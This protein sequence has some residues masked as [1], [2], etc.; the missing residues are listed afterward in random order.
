MMTKKAFAEYVGI[1]VTT[2]NSW[3]Y[4]YNWKKGKQYQV[5]GRTTLIDVKKANEWIMNKDRDND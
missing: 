3:I 1:K 5:I 4:G 2:L